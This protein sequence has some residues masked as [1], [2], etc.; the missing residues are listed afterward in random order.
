ML[1]TVNERRREMGVLKSVGARRKDIMVMAL[2][3]AVLI[4]A[5]GGT[6]GFLAVRIFGAINQ[7]TNGYP[8]LAIVRSVVA[9]YGLAIGLTVTLSL[10][11]GM[12]PAVRLSK[13]TAMQALRGE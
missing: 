11:F 10:L 6:A 3:E 12:I 13:M 1:I 8:V 2:S 9:D 7:I 4:S 5:I